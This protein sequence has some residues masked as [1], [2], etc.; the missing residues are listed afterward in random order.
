MGIPSQKLHK[1]SENQQTTNDHRIGSR[2][3]STRGAD[4]LELTFHDNQLGE[5][6]QNRV[7]KSGRFL[8]FDLPQ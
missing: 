5:S 7:R 4:R 1:Y 3:W 8:N 2:I 6:T